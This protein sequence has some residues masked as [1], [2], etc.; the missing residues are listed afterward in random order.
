[1]LLIAFSSTAKLVTIEKAKEIAIAFYTHNFSQDKSQ[2]V[3]TESDVTEYKNIVTYYI[4]HS[5]P[6]GK[7]IDLEMSDYISGIYILTLQTYCGI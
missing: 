6:G 4:F 7:N 5:Q 2:P 1:M 3:I